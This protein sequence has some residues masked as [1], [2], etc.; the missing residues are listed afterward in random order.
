MR[1]TRVKLPLNFTAASR[2][3]ETWA[4]LRRKAGCGMF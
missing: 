2:S 1:L 4:I 3:F